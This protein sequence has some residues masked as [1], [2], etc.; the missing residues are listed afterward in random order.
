MAGKR[1][2][3]GEAS[4]SAREDTKPRKR[5]AR[6]T[7]ASYTHTS[8]AEPAHR[9]NAKVV[10]KRPDPY[11]LVSAFPL[12]PEAPWACWSSCDPLNSRVGAQV[13]KN[14]YGVCESLPA[15]KKL[16]KEEVDTCECTRPEEE[17]G[18][19][20]PQGCGPDCINRCGSERGPA[21][22]ARGVWA[23]ARVHLLTNHPA[24]WSLQG[25]Q[26]HLRPADVPLRSALQQ[27]PLPDS[28]IAQGALLRLL[29]AAFFEDGS[30]CR[31]GC[32]AAVGT[33]PC[34][35][36]TTT[37]SMGYAPMRLC[38][39]TAGVMLL[40]RRPLPCPADGAVLHGSSRMGRSGLR[41]HPEGHVCGRVLW[42]DR[43]AG[44]EGEVVYRKGDGYNR[45]A[46]AGWGPCAPWLPRVSC[47]ACPWSQECARRMAKAKEEGDPRFYMMQLHSRAII[48]AK[49]RIG[50]HAGPRACAGRVLPSVGISSRVPQHKGG[51]V[52]FLNSCCEPNCKAETWTDSS[53]GE[54]RVG[55][56]TI[57]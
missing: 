16:P 44:G 2:Q 47:E 9:A 42:G 54:K 34:L 7:R 55:L 33:R 32:L 40:R 4:S 52:R 22:I 49:A 31:S 1:A 23:G 43:D 8:T 35:A 38:A 53:T 57:K 41:G 6:S 48:D 39:T 36:A 3:R 28:A 45:L 51:W 56:F 19:D 21:G 17:V 10:P 13:K 15:P 46:C 37:A 29:T 25:N 12:R 26:H 18:P 5:A 30:R 27:R 50:D 14:V 20:G 24:H 11:K